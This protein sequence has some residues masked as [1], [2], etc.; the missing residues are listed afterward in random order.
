[1]FLLGVRIYLESV[2]LPNIIKRVMDIAIDRWGHLARPDL[3][4]CPPWFQNSNVSP[5][6]A[7]GHFG[8]YQIRPPGCYRDA[9][10]SRPP[11]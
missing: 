5:Q 9:F 4:K 11:S 1:M 6:K 7:Q 2:F 10:V 3:L 8:S